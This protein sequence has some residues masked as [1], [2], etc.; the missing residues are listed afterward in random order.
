VPNALGD[1]IASEVKRAEDDYQ[2]V[3]SKALSVVTLAGGLVTL[4]SGL[5]TIAASSRTNLL[6]SDGRWVMGFAIG[7]FVGAGIIALWV[8]VPS[9]VESPKPEALKTLVENNWDDEG[10]DQKTTK[11]MATYLI[12]MSKANNSKAWWL[13]GAISFEIV[14]IGLT[15]ALGI[16]VV[17]HVS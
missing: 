15:G 5:L 1:L 14:G 7:A 4:L 3:R 6:R 13:I 2:G 12:S 10:W 11:V 16:L 17:G 8:N 9:T